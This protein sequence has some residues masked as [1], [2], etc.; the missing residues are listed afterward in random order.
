MEQ[1]VAA[2]RGVPE[3]KFILRLGIP[4]IRDLFEVW[5]VGR[6]A[7]TLGAATSDLA[8]RVGHT[9]EHLLANPFH[10]CLQSHDIDVLTKRYSRRVFQSYVD[11]NSEHAWRLFWMS[12]PNAKEITWIGLAPHP[13]DE[14]NGVYD[15]V[16]LSQ[17][18]PRMTE[19]P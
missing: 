14:K 5:R 13:D 6:E 1:H 9:L 3:R 15:R 19:S 7:D 4:E 8:D 16:R 2:A 12:G 18:P 10:P 11:N 17:L